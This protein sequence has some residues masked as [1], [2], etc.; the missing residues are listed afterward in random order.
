MEDDWVYRMVHPL[1]VDPGA[2]TKFLEQSH[3]VRC[4]MQLS[5]P[6]GKPRGAS[7]FS[8]AVG[9]VLV[10]SLFK[11]MFLNTEAVAILTYPNGQRNERALEKYLCERI[12]SLCSNQ[13]GASESVFVKRVL[14]GRRSYH[15][16]RFSVAPLSLNAGQF[17]TAIVLERNSQSLDIE[18]VADGFSLSQREREVVQ[19]LVR[20]LT[21]KEIAVRMGISPNTVKVFLRL[22]MVKT[23]VTTRSGIVGKILQHFQI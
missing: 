14:L 1:S 7:T 18:Q 15:F 22:V 12:R 19:L 20:G 21:T 6:L 2:K 9:F 10:D 4:P 17:T 13:G 3:L 8:N 11:P 16:R 5:D 23:N